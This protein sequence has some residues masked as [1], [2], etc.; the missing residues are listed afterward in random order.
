MQLMWIMRGVP[1]AGKSYKA[2]KLAEVLGPS[3]VIYSTDDFFLID[4]QYVFDPKKLTEYHARNQQRVEEACRRRVNDVIV[5][6]TC[7]RAW[8]AREYVRIAI[9]NK[10]AVRF[11]EADSPW[12]KDAH[13]CARRNT[14]GVPLET[15]ER[16][17]NNWEPDLSVVKCLEAKAPWEK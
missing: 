12:A 14:H 13:E 2:N 7:V 4:G 8:E 16:M 1:G 5:D 3:T 10:Y 11:L 9:K 15:I 6:N 17:I